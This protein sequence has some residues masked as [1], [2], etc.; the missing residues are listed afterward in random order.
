MGVELN[1]FRA[2]A[3]QSPDAR[4]IVVDGDQAMPD[5]R[6]AT[7]L[8]AAV[9]WLTAN[10]LQY[11]PG[12][13]GRNAQ[14]QIE[15]TLQQEN[16]D[17]VTAFRGALAGEFGDSLLSRSPALATNQPL[18]PERVE[19][20]VARLEITRAADR[21]PC[22]ARA[23]AAPTADNIR[24]AMDYVMRDVKLPPGPH[25]PMLAAEV[26]RALEPLFVQVH[27]LDR[28]PNHDLLAQLGSQLAIR[29]ED[30]L[31]R[32]MEAHVDIASAALPQHERDAARLTDVSVSE[33]VTGLDAAGGLDELSRTIPALRVHLDTEIAGFTRSTGILLTRV[34]RDLVPMGARFF[35]TKPVT[36]LTALVLTNSDPHKG[37]QRVALL[38]LSNGEKLV[39]KPRDVRIDE[40]ITGSDLVGGRRSLLAEAGAAA[41]L[42]KFM[43]CRE[44][45][46]PAPLDGAAPPAVPAVPLHYGYVQFLPH[47][48]ARDHLIEGDAAAREYHT[49]L[50]RGTAALM[51]AG[52]TDIHHENIMVSGGMPYFTDLEFALA[53]PVLDSVSRLLAV[54]DGPAIGTEM[55][56]VMRSVMLDKAMTLATDSN[57]LHAPC[58]VKGD[59]FEMRGEL[60]EV[61]ESLLVVRTD[62]GVLLDN[63][64]LP[65]PAASYA[66]EFG[67]GV[68]AGL[69]SLKDSHAYTDFLDQTADLHVRYH[70][71]GTQ[72]QREILD[73]HLARS[74]HPD[75]GVR[76]DVALDSPLRHTPAAV[77]AGEVRNAPLERGLDSIR[78]PGPHGPHGPPPL[79]PAQRTAM[80]TAMHEAY[81]AHDVPYF[82]RIVAEREVYLDGVKALS[83]PLGPGS[84]RAY[85]PAP[86]DVPAR[87]LATRL[88]ATPADR[89]AAIGAAAATWMAAQSPMNP[90]HID[91]PDFTPK[92]D[93]RRMLAEIA[94]MPRPAVQD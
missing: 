87:A 40:A 35:P 33:L 70:P 66:R 88:T 14:Q 3:Q 30:Y 11:L 27:G 25:G 67:G 89:F 12:A 58:R 75:R 23:A 81:G 44:A 24:A 82:S 53:E 60:D 57:T 19:H 50:G 61:T 84:S 1:Q 47:G 85:F 41:M 9:T 39:Y 76:P 32:A 63:R 55:A 56:Q 68:Q 83:W 28:S 43:P 49:M 36:G 80:R 2:V 29:L 4:R 16:A 74:F 78:S 46:P 71:I 37:G 64:H 22:F 20:Y 34:E 8:G 10:V 17:A 59:S 92:G 65:A 45:P 6:P 86:A 51:M 13:V 52:A 77:L 69:Q 79:D 38:S 5:A 72:Q 21:L 31:L 42:Y 7:R 15:A 90:E 48:T 93:T 54:P 73:E 62:A 18:T 94:A 26:R 91:D